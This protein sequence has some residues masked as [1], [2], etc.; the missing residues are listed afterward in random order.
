M[1]LNDKINTTIDVVI[2]AVIVLIGSLIFWG[3]AI[4]LL[5]L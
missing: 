2:A 3:T 1:T 5:S 4:L